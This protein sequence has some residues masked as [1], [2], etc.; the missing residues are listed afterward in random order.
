[1][2]WS[3]AELADRAGLTPDQISRLEG[4]SRA[5]EL[6]TLDKVARAF[7]VYPGR[8]LDPNTGGM[9][10]ALSDLSAALDR[11]KATAASL[12]IAAKFEI[13]QKGRG[14]KSFGTKVP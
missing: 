14:P 10:V 8:L 13:S 1:M 6:R 3:Q 5:P 12:Q 2:N 9:D 4:E 11:V 7:G